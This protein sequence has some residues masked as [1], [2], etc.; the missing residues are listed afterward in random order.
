VPKAECQIDNL[1]A[2]VDPSLVII[3]LDMQTRCLV[4]TVKTAA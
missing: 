3:I 4:V 1:E 2:V